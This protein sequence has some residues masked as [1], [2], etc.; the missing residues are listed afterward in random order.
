MQTSKSFRAYELGQTLLLPP[1]LNDWL[2]EGHLA[3]F[4]AET[5]ATLDLSAFFASYEDGRGMSAYHPQ[6]M[7]SVLVYGYCTGVR[8]S[9]KLAAAC[10]E[11]VAFRYLSGNSMPSH[12]SFASFRRRHLGAMHDLFVRVF[13]LCREAGLVR[14]GHV[15]I[16][17]S[18]FKANASKHKAVSWGR[19][20]ERQKHYREIAEELT[21]R[22][23]NADAQEDAEHGSDNDGSC[24][25]DELKRAEGRLTRLQEAKQALEARARQKAEEERERVEHRLEDIAHKEEQTGRKH[26]GRKPALPDPDKAE[27]EVKDQYNFTDPDSRIML[28]GATKGFTYAFNAQIGVDGESGVIVGTYL[29]DHPNDKNELIPAIEAITANTDGAT[30]EKISADNGYFSEAVLGDSRVAGLDLYIPPTGARRKTG[31]PDGAEGDGDHLPPDA[32]LSHAETMRRK[33][34]TPEG[35]DVYKMRKA[36]AEAPFGIIKSVMGFRAFSVRGRGRV[37]GEWDLVTAAYNLRKLFGARK[38]VVT[39]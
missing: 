14:L 24:L 36:I 22:A 35:R 38:A 13:E 18:K 20:E 6:M 10:Q 21:Q 26:P 16:D 11:N 12:E 4:V 25:P 33:L 19:I 37:D 9:R 15:G 28:D 27:P 31:G 30:P 3:R 8:S 29:S 7:L 17:G 23:E 39:A 34:Q 32:N 2:P 1:D 5:M